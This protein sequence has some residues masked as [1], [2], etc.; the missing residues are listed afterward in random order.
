MKSP[1]H[2]IG[3]AMNQFSSSQSYFALTCVR[4]AK[5]PAALDRL[6]S[7][8]FEMLGAAPRGI[9]MTQVVLYG[10]P[11]CHLCDIAY[12]LLL[13]LRREFE[14]EIEKVNI[15]AD[16]DLLSKYGEKIPVVRIDN[17]V[18]LYAPIRVDDLRK[19]LSSTSPTAT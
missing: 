7:Q 12:E 5:L 17:R 8:H 18:V 10:K 2:K 3:T 1:P 13:G 16:P 14:F 4:F 9:I 11:G 15:A 19:H 6:A